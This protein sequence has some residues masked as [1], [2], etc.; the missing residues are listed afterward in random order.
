MPYQLG[1]D[2]DWQTAT[3]FDFRLGRA[4]IGPIHPIGHEMAGLGM[5]L[6][7]PGKYLPGPN[8]VRFFIDERQVKEVVAENPVPPEIIALMK[9]VLGVDGTDIGG[10]TVWEVPET[11][12]TP[13][14]PPPTTQVITT[15]PSG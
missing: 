9:D 3:G 2:M 10:V 4:Y 11:G 1:S 15:A 14:E 7:E 13:H 8:A 12:T 5:I 6:T